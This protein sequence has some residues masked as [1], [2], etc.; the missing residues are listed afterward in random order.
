MRTEF[1]PFT[2]WPLLDP[3]MLLGR[4]VCPVDYRQD[5]FDTLRFAFGD[6]IAVSVV[7]CVPN[8]RTIGPAPKPKR[9]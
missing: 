2:Q 1:V 9:R 4:R 6:G 3:A 5:R 8:G 7:E